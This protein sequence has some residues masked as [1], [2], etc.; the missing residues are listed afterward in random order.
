MADGPAS[1][2]SA[3]L[4]VREAVLALAAAE[5]PGAL[6]PHQERAATTEKMA[7]RASRAVPDSPQPAATDRV[8][9]PGRARRNVSY[10][11]DLTR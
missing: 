7:P 8:E 2:A 1:S 3:G 9:R 6:A 10:T 11:T 4:Q 5:A